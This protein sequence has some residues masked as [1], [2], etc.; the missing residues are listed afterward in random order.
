MIETKIEYL[1]ARN[2]LRLFSDFKTDRSVRHN[3]H[4]ND[5]TK[6]LGLYRGRLRSLEI[7]GNEIFFGE[8][9]NA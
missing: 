4:R 7:S 3:L 6:N 8:N 1:L 9:V 5:L 2:I